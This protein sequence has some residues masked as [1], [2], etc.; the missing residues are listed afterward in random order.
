MENIAGPP[1]D[2]PNFF[3]RD[4]EIQRL[5]QD[6][7]HHDV[8]LLGAR[9]I[10]KTS[11]AREIM[12][13]LQEQGWRA[14]EINV[15]SCESERS[16]IEKLE[17]AVQAALASPLAK[18]WSII[19][20]PFVALGARIKK[21]D[22]PL[23]GA[24]SAGVELKDQD[25]EDW[26]RVASDVI[27]LISAA[28]SPCLIYVDEL[29]IFLYNLIRQD[30]N[31]GVQRVR[32]F[33]N[34]FRNDVRAAP[35]AQNVRWLI[36]GS[37]GLDTLVQ[38]H[39]MADTINSLRPAGL[40]PFTQGEALALVMTLA[41]RYAIPM[42]VID[43]Q[44]LLDEIRWLQPYYIQYAFSQFRSLHASQPQEPLRPLI[45]RAVRSLA[46]VGQD[47]DLVHWQERLYL[48]LPPALADHAVNLLTLSASTSQ[49]ER[50][51]V[52]FARL[53]E[54][55]PDLPDE[56]ARRVFGQ[57]RDILERDAYWVEAEEP[58]ARRY[59]FA[60]EPLRRWWVRRHS[61]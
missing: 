2:A 58:S 59:R 46:E 42:Q 31:H 8:L 14:I 6:L 11:I 16:F 25:A 43:A 57:L 51:D 19:K 40:A 61:I 10:G 32:R 48:Q 33:L 23:P 24:G 34:W 12:R 35:Q 55:T 36:S 20:E 15:A 4:A 38:Q 22:V 60:L 52:L 44:A 54:R 30:P 50:I 21:I 47:N 45:E 56:Q 28:E 27:G 18:T 49:G 1:V 5:I 53:Q 9:R 7:A 39:G 37:V 29:P 41:D 17:A 13:R 26:V 3:G